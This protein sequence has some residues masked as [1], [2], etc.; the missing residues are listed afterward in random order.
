MTDKLSA[1]VSELEA[2]PATAATPHRDRTAVEP[3][4]S[5]AR[6]AAPVL[7]Q[8]G[9][10]VIAAAQSPSSRHAG[11]G[12]RDLHGDHRRRRDGRASCR[13]T[14]RRRERSM[15]QPLAFPVRGRRA[16]RISTT[17]AWRA[18]DGGRTARARA[19]VLLVGAPLYAGEARVRLHRLRRQ[20]SQRPHRF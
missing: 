6:A 5:A 1:K 8:A 18:V 17:P 4:R 20:A 15:R 7:L 12:W 10:E 2:H 16:T 14:C 19:A 9:R 3:Y 11:R 13:P